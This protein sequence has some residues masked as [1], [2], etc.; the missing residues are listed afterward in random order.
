MITLEEYRSNL[1]KKISSSANVA[2]LPQFREDV[3]T[4]E[5]LS[6]LIEADIL[7]NPMPSP[8]KSHGVAV[9]AY[10]FDDEIKTLH[11]IVTSYEGVETLPTLPNG[12]IKKI[13]TRLEKFYN[14]STTGLHEKID[15]SAEANDLSLIIE[16]NKEQI[17]K[18]DFTIVTDMV[19]RD[20]PGLDIELNHNVTASLSVW[21]IQRF[22]RYEHSGKI[23]Q[24]I[25]INVKD[26]EFE[27]INAT[28]IPSDEKSYDIYIGVMSG[29]LLFNLYERWGTRLLERNVRAYLQARGAVNREI[30]R[31]I[32]ESPNMFMAYNNGL[33]ITSNSIKYDKTTDESMVHILEIGDFQIVNGGQTIA[34]IWHAKNIYKDVDLS[35]INVQIKL[36][37]IKSN[38]NI[39]EIAKAISYATNRQNAVNRADFKALHPY[40][41]DLEKRSRSTWAPDPTGGNIE[42]KWFYERARG[43]YDETRNLKRTEAEKRKWTA[44]NPRSQKFDKLLLAKAVQTF[45]LLPDKV[46]L[47]AQKNF[48]DFSISI[49][50]NNRNTVD[51]IDFKDIVAKVILWKKTERIVSAQKTPG[52]RAQ[53]VTYT[54]ALVSYLLQ[55]RINFNDIWQNLAIQEELKEIID[56]YAYKV[57]EHLTDTEAN[58]TEYAKKEAVWIALKKKLDVDKNTI[59]EKIPNSLVDPNEAKKA[60]K[61]KKAP[62]KQLKLI[63]EFAPDDWFA[64]AKWGRSTNHLTP[65]QRS[66]AFNIG[67]HLKSGKEISN[68]LGYVGEIIIKKAKEMGFEPEKA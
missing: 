59:S 50:E 4:E 49:Q 14:R 19:C 35:A 40:H 5:A 66:Q 25:L 2:D 27:K 8:Y 68:S 51:D 38:D 34:S 52:Y 46:C 11:L 54:L 16:N 26:Y 57:R 36:V 55:G 3:F 20:Q 18:V 6:I 44:R 53:I 22:Y 30:R 60:L 65:R 31:T 13:F 48:H 62:K 7:D 12:E 21:D 47:G 63:N 45:E 29:Q 15:E 42:T 37:V 17:K 58:V 1:L 61:R 41:I 64:A 39:E 28:I 56:Y 67:R 33:T 32:K 43:L 10:D 23:A 24:E 9:N